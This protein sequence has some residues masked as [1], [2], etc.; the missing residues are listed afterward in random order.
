MKKPVRLG[1]IKCDF[2]CRNFAGTILVCLSVRTET[3][4]HFRFFG[5]KIR[6]EYESAKTQ[7]IWPYHHLLAIFHL[8]SQVGNMATEQVDVIVIGGGLSGLNAA[9][10]LSEAGYKVVVLEARDRVGGR[11]F[12]LKHKGLAVDLGTE[13]VRFL[14]FY[15]LR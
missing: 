15:L 1:S 12:T 5:P 10:H 7:P 11:T 14:P 13:P 6:F 9:R 3:S 4:F 8:P 2:D